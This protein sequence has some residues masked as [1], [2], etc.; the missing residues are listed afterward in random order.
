MNEA[1]NKIGVIAEKAFKSGEISLFECAAIQCCVEFM[2][3]EL[4][5]GSAVAKEFISS[6]GTGTAGAMAT[7]V[8]KKQK[9]ITFEQIRKGWSEYPGFP[10]AEWYEERGWTKQEFYVEHTKKKQIK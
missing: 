7:L 1:T 5:N 2:H 9:K 4:E 10:P 3:A 6:Y 8:H